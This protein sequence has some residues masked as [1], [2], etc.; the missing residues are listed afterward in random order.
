MLRVCKECEIEI[1]KNIGA[2]YVI[3]GS[4]SKIDELYVLLV[5]LHATDNSNLMAS[6]SIKTES[7]KELVEWRRAGCRCCSR[8]TECDSTTGA[9]N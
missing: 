2:D 9:I 8:R 1:A 5:R 6:Q 3:S 4:I 7:K